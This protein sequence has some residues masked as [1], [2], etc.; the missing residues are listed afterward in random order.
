MFSELTVLIHQSYYCLIIRLSSTTSSGTRPHSHHTIAN[1]LQTPPSTKKRHKK[2]VQVPIV[3]EKRTTDCGHRFCIPN[4][5]LFKPKVSRSGANSDTP[6]RDGE[7]RITLIDNEPSFYKVKDNKVKIE[8]VASKKAVQTV[9]LLETEI[10]PLG[11]PAYQ[12]FSV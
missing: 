11:C 3:R 7:W 4:V 2:E 6:G 5:A 10:I 8:S 1:A 9:A 12:E